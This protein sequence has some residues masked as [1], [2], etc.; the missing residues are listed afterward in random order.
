MALLL[1]AAAVAARADVL[2]LAVDD[3]RPELACFEV[4][5]AVRPTLHTPNICGLA[6][7]SLVLQV[8]CLC[9]WQRMR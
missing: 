5:G 8:D 7:E 9:E 1:H 2:M 4:P 6:K 3:L